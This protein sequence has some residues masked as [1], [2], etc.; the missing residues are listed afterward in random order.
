[1]SRGK[2]EKIQEE[3]REKEIRNPQERRIERRG[4]G[5]GDLTKSDGTGLRRTEKQ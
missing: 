2:E 3:K 1:M 4:K 5:E